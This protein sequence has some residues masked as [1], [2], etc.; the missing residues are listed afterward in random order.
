MFKQLC[1]LHICHEEVM[2]VWVMTSTEYFDN[3]IKTILSLEHK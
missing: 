1:K 3:F 2:Q